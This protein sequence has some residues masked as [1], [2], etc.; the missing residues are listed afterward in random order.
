M[1]KLH[2][3]FPGS[4]YIVTDHSLQ[5]PADAT[6]TIYAPGLQGAPTRLEA[7]G[8]VN[9]FLNGVKGDGPFGFQPSVFD[10]QPGT[11]GWSP[12]WDHYAYQWKH[13]RDARV[14][15]SEE[16]INAARRSGALRRFAGVPDTKGTLFTVNCQVPI[17]APVTL[18]KGP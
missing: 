6:R 16:S 4:R 2:R 7:T 17:V 15:R 9:P 1:F 5:G 8:R 3:C 12:Y 18:P 13:P 14:L 11:P 10:S